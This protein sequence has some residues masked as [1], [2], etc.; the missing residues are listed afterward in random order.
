MSLAQIRENQEPDVSHSIVSMNDKAQL[1]TPDR[2]AHVDMT[3]AAAHSLTKK[4]LGD[5]FDANKHRV[6]FVKSVLLLGR[7]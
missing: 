4:L 5:R 6:R 2:V 1:R 7:V 3:E